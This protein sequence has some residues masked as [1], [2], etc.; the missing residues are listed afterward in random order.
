[1]EA[2]THPRWT[3]LMP[4]A[5][6][7]CL[8]IKSEI[9]RLR[10]EWIWAHKNTASQE[11]IRHD[12]TRLHGGFWDRARRDTHGERERIDVGG[13]IET[14]RTAAREAR[15]YGSSLHVDFRDA[16]FQTINVQFKT[17]IPGWTGEAV[18]FWR[19]DALAN[20]FTAM[21]SS[22]HPYIDWLDG[23][24]N[25][26]MVLQRAAEL[27]HFWLHEVDKTRMPR[28]WLRSAF[29]FQQ[30]FHKVTD[31]TP[32]D[33]QLGSYLVDVDLML[34][35]DKNLV[36]MAKRCE[37]EAPFTMAH[38]RAIPAGVDAVGAVMDALKEPEV[39]V[40]SNRSRAEP[41]CA[42]V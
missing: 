29:E 10:P 26:R 28:H 21:H 32:C 25:L 13:A 9:S 14:A 31:G 24:I 11:K 12:W 41:F 19:F 6:H 18:E 36:R 30:Q 34:S 7:E 8:E 5:F 15:K 23:E 20:F 3:R 16:A 1:M 42:V 39:G 40:P 38:S 37:R 22:G 17:P 35:A 33:A 4:D 2:L 27:T